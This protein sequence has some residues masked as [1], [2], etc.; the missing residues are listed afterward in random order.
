LVALVAA[1][2]AIAR[3]QVV[4]AKN[5]FECFINFNAFYIQKAIKTLVI[6]IITYSVSG[7]RLPLIVHN[8]LKS[9]FYCF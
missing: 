6:E 9:T 8:I 5:A 4:T 7:F 1:T 3:K 2:P